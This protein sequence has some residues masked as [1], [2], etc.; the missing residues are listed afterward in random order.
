MFS[1]SLCLRAFT[2]LFQLS[3][4]DNFRSPSK[5]VDKCFD[6]FRCVTIERPGAP[7]AKA[8]KEFLLY[9]CDIGIYHN[10]N[11]VAQATSGAT[12][13]LDICLDKSCQSYL[14]RL[15][16]E[17]QESA[18]LILVEAKPL[19]DDGKLILH[20]P[21]EFDPGV[22]VT[23]KIESKESQFQMEGYLA[24]D[25]KLEHWIGFQ[26]DPDTAYTISYLSDSDWVKMAQFNTGTRNGSA[27]GLVLSLF[28]L[29]V[30]VTAAIVI[31][32]RYRHI[33]EKHKVHPN[34]LLESGRIK[35]K[36]VLIISNVDNRFHIDIVLA[37]GKYLK[38]HCAVGEVYF[39]LD[40]HTRI[41]SQVRILKY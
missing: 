7:A 11:G 32:R 9:D 31:W 10:A 21:P 19:R 27:L 14:L 33:Q 6:N 26:L 1:L 41:T 25:M 13:S 38:T 3:N 37:F 2:I 22:N 35:A 23:L 29:V 40:P 4:F 30:V 28:L 20:F 24:Q 16:E 15:P 5:V 36:N 8:A 34:R 12:Y 17:Q 39:A 18:G